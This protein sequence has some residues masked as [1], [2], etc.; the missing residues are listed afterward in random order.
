MPFLTVSAVSR[1]SSPAEGSAGPRLTASSVVR[2]IA[3]SQR[4]RD[5]ALGLSI[6]RQRP[7]SSSTRPASIGSHLTQLA[8]DFASLAAEATVR[9]PRTAGA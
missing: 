9:P 3:S 5:A 8:A 6:I 7:R 1:S 2:A 4:T